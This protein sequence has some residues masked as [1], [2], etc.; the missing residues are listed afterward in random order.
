[1][2]KLIENVPVP[3]DTDA[4]D[5]ATAVKDGLPVTGVVIS[6]WQD[7]LAMIRGEHYT[8]AILE[9]EERQ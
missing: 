2:T 9:V 5:T 3:L 6:V 8:F 1:M 7:P 4:G